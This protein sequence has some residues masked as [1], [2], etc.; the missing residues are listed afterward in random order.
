MH[1][2]L[3][4]KNSK[5]LNLR[6]VVG[7]SWRG[8]VSMRGMPGIAYFATGIHTILREKKSLLPL[9]LMGEL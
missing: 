8:V 6:N 2:L 7:D 9:S 4:N 1:V 5:G 3:W